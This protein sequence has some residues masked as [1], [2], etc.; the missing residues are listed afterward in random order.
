MFLIKRIDPENNTRQQAVITI[1]F[2]LFVT[3][4]LKLELQDAYRWI[5]LIFSPETDMLIQ[6][7][8]CISFPLVI[9]L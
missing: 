3:S 2:D 5:C 7:L 4:L 9:L 6:A 8:R 1:S